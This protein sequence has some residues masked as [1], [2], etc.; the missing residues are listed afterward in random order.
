MWEMK[1]SRSQRP[2]RRP[3]L[4][5]RATGATKISRARRNRTSVSSAGT[6][7]VPLAFTRRDPSSDPKNQEAKSVK[8]ATGS[9]CSTSD[10]KITQVRLARKTNSSSRTPSSLTPLIKRL[11]LK[12]RDWRSFRQSSPLS[13]AGSLPLSLRTGREHLKQKCNLS[14]MSKKLMPSSRS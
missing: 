1:S 9:S 4:Q 8:Y 12:L 3:Y 7:P 5:Q 14:T 13:R 2:E 10:T 6:G 11:Y